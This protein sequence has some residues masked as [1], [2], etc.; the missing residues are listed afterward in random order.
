MS[1]RRKI[2]IGAFVAGGA[3]AV[4]APQVAAQGAGGT[5][6]TGAC[7]GDRLQVR[8]LQDRPKLLPAKRTTLEHLVRLQRPKRLPATRLPIEHQVFTFVALVGDRYR[9]RNGDIRAVV[10][11]LGKP[12]TH[13]VA[14]AAPAPAC[15]SRATNDLRR[16][17]GLARQG[18]IRSVC[19]RVKVTGVAFFTTRPRTWLTP[20]RNGIE[21]H[22]LLNFTCVR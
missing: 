20:A 15:N 9:E 4:L 17:M 1:T 16:Q 5:R 8:T 18:M 19:S 3:L 7:G 6:L 14:V 13:A 12:L 22:P 11:Q 2:G 21:L 10:P